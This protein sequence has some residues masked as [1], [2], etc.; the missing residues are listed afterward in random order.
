MTASNN[1]NIVVH[2]RRNLGFPIMDLEVQIT[3]Y[4][5]EDYITVTLSEQW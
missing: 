5:D 1:M 3:H 2:N 4:E